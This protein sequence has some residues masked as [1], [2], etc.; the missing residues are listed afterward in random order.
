MMMYH[1]SELSS[2]PQEGGPVISE[3]VNSQSIDQ[4]PRTLCKFIRDKIYLKNQQYV[5]HFEK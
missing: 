3:K 1:L 4:L 5:P 2:L